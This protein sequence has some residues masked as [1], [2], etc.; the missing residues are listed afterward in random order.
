M[1]NI[2]FRLG[3]CKLAEQ[4]CW[5]ELGSD[6]PAVIRCTWWGTFDCPWLHCLLHCI[7]GL[8]G[9]NCWLNSVLGSHS[10]ASRPAWTCSE[11]SGRVPW[12]GDLELEH[13]HFL[14]ILLAR[15]NRRPAQGWGNRPHLLTGE[16]AKSHYRGGRCR[17][18]KNW[19][20]FNKSGGQGVGNLLDFSE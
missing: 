9:D 13:W 15:H 20:H 16:A 5:S 11:G 1:I 2:D 19:D 12:R 18:G 10:L 14:C 6:V 17:E 3:A 8:G 4:F 7:W